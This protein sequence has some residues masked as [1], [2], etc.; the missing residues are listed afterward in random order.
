MIHSTKF[1][2][3]PL[4]SVGI[5]ELAVQVGEQVPARDRRVVAAEDF[6]RP[7]EVVSIGEAEFGAVQEPRH[8]ARL[9]Y[10]RQGQPYGDTPPIA[11]APLLEGKL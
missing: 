2:I 4:I 11:P 7:L 5:A 3:F 8:A 9:Q 6:A 10:Q 1:F